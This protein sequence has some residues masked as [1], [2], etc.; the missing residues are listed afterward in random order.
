VGPALPVLAER[1][2]VHLLVGLPLDPVD[3]GEPGFPA[4]RDVGEARSVRTE[5]EGSRASAEPVPRLALL[6]VED[7][8]DL[9]VAARVVGQALAV[10][11]EDREADGLVLLAFLPVGDDPALLPRRTAYAT[12]G[13]FPA[14]VRRARR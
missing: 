2:V 6:A 10:A 9:P 4:L 11:A 5:L 3:H 13:P 12:R 7:D 14:I 8:D 1:E